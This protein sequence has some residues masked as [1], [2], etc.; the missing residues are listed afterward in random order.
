MNSGTT[1]KNQR[2]V[3]KGRVKQTTYTLYLH[4]AA[5]FPT[6]DTW[7]AVVKAGNFA[8]WPGLTEQSIKRHFPES[9]E[10]QC[11]HLKKQRQHVR[12][13]KQALQNQRMN[14]SPQT[15]TAPEKDII[16]MSIFNTCDTVYTD[17][18]GKFPIT[19]NRGNKYI[20]VMHEVG[21]NYIDAEPLKSRAENELVKAYETLYERLTRTNKVTPKLHVLDN[22]APTILKKVIKLQCTMQLAPPDTHR[23]NL[24][25][26]AIQTFKGHFISVLSGVDKNFPMEIWDR[27]IPQMLRQS[28]LNPNVSA[29]EYINGKPFD[30][31]AMTNGVRCTISRQR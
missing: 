23:R 3:E 10:T 5:G 26:R 31:N 14:N 24:A 25:E 18:T 17:Q 4:A 12:S 28:K 20:M 11:G 7:I 27:L 22:E 8:T 6:K 19:L 29:Y 21:S 9:N 2:R 16:H 1:S 30:Y 15:D 13:T